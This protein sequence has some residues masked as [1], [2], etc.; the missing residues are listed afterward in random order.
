MIM[1]SMMQLSG[2]RSEAT[3]A[4][5]ETSEDLI[6]RIRA[7]LMGEGAGIPGPFGPRGQ[8]YADYTASGRMLNFVEAALGR[9]VAPYYANTHSEASYT[10][11]QTA[12]LREEAREAIRRAVG[13]DGRHAVIFCGSGATAAINKLAQAMGL[14]L[15]VA[16]RDRDLLLAQV[17]TKARPVVFVGPFEH[18]S[19]DLPWRESLATVVRIPLDSAGGPSEET[20]RQKLAEYADRPL[21][22]GA[23]SAASNVSGAKADVRALAHLLHTHGALCF[24]DYAAGAPYLPIDMAESAPGKDDHCDAIFLSPHKFVGGPGASGVLVADRR[25]FS[26]STPSAPGGGTVSFVTP[27]D[28]RYV[29]DIETREEAGTPGIMGDIRAGMMLQLK[30]DVGVEQIEARERG[31]VERALS[32]WREIPQI[33]LLGPANPDRLAI[34]S[35][36]L[37]SGER[38]L[39]HGFVVTVL[40]D[41]FGLQA[42]GGCSCAGPYGH[43]LLGIDETLSS[44][45]RDLIEQGLGLFKPGWVRIGLNFFFDA[46]TIGSIIEAVAFIACRG[47]DLLPL[48]QVDLRSGLWQATGGPVPL[49]FGFEDLRGAWLDQTGPVVGPAVLP[50]FAS[51][52]RQAEQLADVGRKAEAAPVTV[53]QAAESLRW[54]WLP[55]E[56]SGSKD[57]GAM[58]Y[59]R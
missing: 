41:L 58:P 12:R 10:G 33:E 47:R 13:A 52:L 46:A 59:S 16:E 14:R 48:Y 38:M 25:L 29:S 21:K 45:Y 27:A 26:H 31:A 57:T 44:R 50:D 7:D 24:L 1:A 18:H 34:F 51:C 36:N 56:A 28:H 53:P 32:R 55:S 9:I 2:R 8:I 43:D 5:R 11:R 6:G 23:F 30:T 54:F 20:L 15:P 19:N 37:R 3:R 35:F 49:R 40:N 4:Q 39:H 22:I 17:P 42:R